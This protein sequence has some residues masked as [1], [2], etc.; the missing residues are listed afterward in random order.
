MRFEYMDTHVWNKLYHH[1]NFKSEIRRGGRRS[2]LQ[3]SSIVWP[4]RCLALRCAVQFIPLKFSGN[5]ALYPALAVPCHGCLQTAGLC[6]KSLNFRNSKTSSKIHC[7]DTKMI[8][9]VAGEFEGSMIYQNLSVQD[10]RCRKTPLRVFSGTVAKREG[11]HHQW[12]LAFKTSH[13]FSYNDSWHGG[14]IYDWFMCIHTVYMQWLRS[15]LDK[16]LD[17]FELE[18]LDFA[19]TWD[20]STVV[21]SW[22]NTSIPYI[23]VLSYQ[24]NW[25]QL[26]TLWVQKP[27]TIV[28]KKPP[29][30]KQPR[31]PTWMISFSKGWENQVKQ[32]SVKI[33]GSRVNLSASGCCLGIRKNIQSTKQPKPL[34]DPDPTPCCSQDA[35]EVVTGSSYCQLNDMPDE[36]AA[37][38]L[39]MTV[40]LTKHIKVQRYMA[41]TRNLPSSWFSG[42]WCISNMSFLSF[43]V[44]F[45]WTMIMGE[46]VWKNNGCRVFGVGRIISVI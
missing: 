18:F 40:A 5:L 6:W 7:H 41:A 44:M 12:R 1:K 25:W 14:W 24:L 22:E 15:P 30:K 32:T 33:F 11:W 9:V 38:V 36:E 17:T 23:T 4:P 45:H 31:K 13:R 10:E 26:R 43:R 2:W 42:K 19:I 27:Q 8:P 29:A 20:G 3:N 21:G 39:K 46:R 35:L 37:E 16:C 34:V 28:S